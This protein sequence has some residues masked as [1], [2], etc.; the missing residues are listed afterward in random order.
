MCLLLNLAS[1]TSACPTYTGKIWSNYSYEVTLNFNLSILATQIYFTVQRFY[2][3]PLA[4]CRLLHCFSTNLIQWFQVNRNSA[5]PK[6]Q[7]SWVAR[8]NSGRSI[9]KSDSLKDSLWL[10]ESRENIA[11]ME[12]DLETYQGKL[13][14]KVIIHPVVN[15]L[16]ICNSV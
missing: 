4:L 13:S 9:L 11:G 5:K 16:N 15:T 2:C 14:P 10:K 1:S 3:F 7:G 12:K 6:R 8:S